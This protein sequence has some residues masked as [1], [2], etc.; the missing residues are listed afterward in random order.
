MEDELVPLIEDVTP[1][2]RIEKD[3]GDEDRGSA[4]QEEGTKMICAES[5]E[6]GIE[7]FRTVERMERNAIEREENEVDLEREHEEDDQEIVLGEKLRT[8]DHAEDESGDDRTDGV[9]EW[10]CTRDGS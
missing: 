7:E 10:P 6:D 4:G 2:Y 5:R 1:R 9:H 8:R 3:D